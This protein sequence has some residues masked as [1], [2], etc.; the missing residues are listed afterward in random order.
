[1]AEDLS[2]LHKKIIALI[3]RENR[4][5]SGIATAL[6]RSN[7]Q[8]DQNKVMTTLIDLEKRGL[9][10]RSTSKAWAAKGKAADYVDVEE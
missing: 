10:E 7:V 8:I 2:E 4:R 1:M 5:P 6:S 9:V 3:I